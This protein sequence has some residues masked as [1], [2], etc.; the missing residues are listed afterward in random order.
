MTIIKSHIIFNIQN[1]NL[2]SNK[3]CFEIGVCDLRL[4]SLGQ[5]A[6]AILI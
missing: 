5:T 3:W 1:S 2:K 4:L 6:L